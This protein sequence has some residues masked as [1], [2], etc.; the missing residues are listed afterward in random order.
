MRAVGLEGERTVG[1]FRARAR[2]GVP[3]ETRRGLEGG[4][5]WDWSI[6]PRHSAAGSQSRAPLPRG[7]R[8]VLLGSGFREKGGLFSNLRGSFS[9][10]PQGN[11][12]SPAGAG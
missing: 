10:T 9:E 4:T 3:R 12:E 1:G 7:R 8:A 6:P 2:P 5:G 11:L